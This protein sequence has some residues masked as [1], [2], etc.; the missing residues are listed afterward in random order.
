M[1]PGFYVIGPQT[2]DKCLFCL[3]KLA[4]EPLTQVDREHMFSFFSENQVA[5]KFCCLKHLH[6][7]G[8]SQ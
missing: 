1:G 2:K 6:E 8:E 3:K 7:E 4:I 5:T